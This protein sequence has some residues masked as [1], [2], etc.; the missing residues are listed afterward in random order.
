MG[1]NTSGSQEYAPGAT[2]SVDLY[3]HADY[4]R[5]KASGMSDYDIKKLIDADPSKMGNGGTS[6]DLYKQI[7]SSAKPPQQAPTPAPAPAPQKPAPRKQEVTR[8]AGSQEF[9]NNLA[10]ATEAYE[11]EEVDMKDFDY[12]N[13]GK[14]DN[15]GEDFNDQVQKEQVIK[16][17]DPFGDSWNSTDFYGKHIT[18]GREAQEGR[19]DASGIANKYIFNAAQTNPVD[20]QALDKQIRTNPLYSESKAE[21]SK[22]KTYGD[23]YANSQQNP[24]NWTNPEPAA[25]YE[26]PDFSNMYDKYT[27]DIKD[28]S[29]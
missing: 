8:K 16:Q 19:Q 22:T 26:A 6:G 27:K 29:I 10:E 9:Q 21:L 1:L 5:D 12:D 20:V 28:I 2:G 7:S 24:V 3:G 14:H 11:P 17:T 13:G 18:M 4:K 15:L 23:T 25:S